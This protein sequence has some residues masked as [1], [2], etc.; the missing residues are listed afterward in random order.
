MKE[1]AWEI[2]MEED[3]FNVDNQKTSSK[4]GASVSFSTIEEFIEDRSLTQLEN[5]AVEFLN[6][7]APSDYVNSMI[8]ESDSEKEA[9]V[10][11]GWL[12][13]IQSDTPLARMRWSHFICSGNDLLKDRDG[14]VF[15]YFR[16]VSE[17]SFFLKHVKEHWCPWEYYQNHFFYWFLNRYQ[18]PLALKV[19]TH[20]KWIS[21][22]HVWGSLIL[23]ILVLVYFLFY[24]TIPY[25]FTFFTI[26][27]AGVIGAGIVMAKIKHLPVRYLIHALVPRLAGTTA[28][29]YLFLLSIPQFI[30]DLYFNRF[31]SAIQVIVAV[32]LLILIVAFILLHIHKRVRPE[33]SFPE[34]F[35]RGVQLLIIASAYSSL[36]LFFLHNIIFINIINHILYPLPVGGSQL[37]LL[38]A[39]S[40]AIGV[41]LQLIWEEKP[42]TEPL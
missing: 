27:I 35:Q 3:I 38:A 37:F 2:K 22:Y 33:L 20:N 23:M 31:G 32:L 30:L 34:L 36:G 19:F 4:S 29:G 15:E 13:W 42:V 10:F 26:S 8:G 5:D 39:I 24:N 16:K 18:I 12:R 21:C 14:Y 11:N 6:A 17:K 28:I 41:L 1:E 7:Q 40:L 25:A 9:K